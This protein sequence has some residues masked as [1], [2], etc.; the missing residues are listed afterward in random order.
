M[1]ISLLFYEFKCLF[2]V[3]FSNLY[4]ATETFAI[5]KSLLLCFVI[6]F[7]GWFCSLCVEKIE[8]NT[9]EFEESFVN[10][11]FRIHQLIQNLKIRFFQN[12]FF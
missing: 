10:S 11:E 3:V 12:R 9:N 2:Y 1:G 6:H 8:E 4:F 7:F 5:D